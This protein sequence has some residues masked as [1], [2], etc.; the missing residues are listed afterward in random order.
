MIDISSEA[1]PI[2]GEKLAATGMPRVMWLLNHTSAR[3]FEVPML[4]ACGFNEIFLPK[5]HPVDPSFRSAS[6]DFSEDQNLTIPA[7]DLAVLNAADWYGNPGRDAWAVANRHFSLLFFI[8][9]TAEALGGIS[10]HFEGAAIWRAYG[11]ERTNS[12]SNIRKHFTEGV[13]TIERMGDR[14]WFGEAYQDLRE[15]EDEL[16]RRRSVYLPLGLPSTDVKEGWTGSDG[17][18]FFVCPDIGFNPYYRAIFEEFTREFAGLPYAIGGSQPIA[19][20]DPNV[21]GFVPKEAHELN[22]RQMRVMFYHSREPRHVHYHPFEAVRAGM[23]LVFM[24]DGMLDKLGGIGLPGRA[25]TVAE[26]RS[27]IQRLLQGDAR[28]IDEI[29]T[30]QR[31]L[32]ESM[33]PNS[34]ENTWRRNLTHVIQRL[35]VASASQIALPTRKKRIAIILPIAYRG[36]TLRAAKL[37]AEAVSSGAEQAGES[38]E[39]VLLHLDL[40]SAYSA[41]DWSDLP[42]SVTT[43]TFNWSILDKAEA[44]TAMLFDG[45]SDWQPVYEKYLVADDGV[46]QL[47]DCDLWIIVSDRLSLPILPMRPVLLIVFDYLQR[48]YRVSDIDEQILLANRLA[49]HVLVTTDFTRQD[50]LQYAG[51]DPRRLTKVPM[52]VPGKGKT[53]RQRNDGDEATHFIW[54]TNL[55]A[56]KNH[57][58]ALAALQLYY[59]AYQGKLTCHVTGFGSREIIKSQLPH[60][61]GLN[62]VVAGSRALRQHVRFLGELSD[63]GYRRELATS[64]FLWHPTELDNGTFSVIEAAHHGIPSLSSD[65]PAMREMDRQFQL[66]LSFMDQEDAEDMAAQLHAMELNLVER[67]RSLATE[68]QLEDQSVERLAPRYWHVIRELL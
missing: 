61:E 56:H 32:L 26:A 4:K 37:L 54:T 41:K 1:R 17:R 64:A 58:R 38:A 20:A 55:A 9:H 51:V 50:A 31:V 46:K 33:R 5:I 14:F 11:L 45:H 66:G 24:A 12:Y 57:R 29:R 63:E 22:M 48:H 39:V 59:E 16:I 62:R 34:L 15:V 67:R 47:G 65:Y 23:P 68:K 28:L 42:P 8:V 27:K 52:L 19:V 49:N 13:K 53:V 30:S 10:A 60:L 36:G 2:S 40:P 35:Q 43:R 25:R 44:E 6:I 21:L 7:T 18:V 3:R